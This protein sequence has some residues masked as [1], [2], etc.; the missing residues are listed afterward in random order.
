MIT[1]IMEA[2]TLSRRESEEFFHGVASA[3]TTLMNH[4]GGPPPRP[5]AMRKILKSYV[6]ASHP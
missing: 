1:I 3:M 2:P 4:Y 6:E 5:Q